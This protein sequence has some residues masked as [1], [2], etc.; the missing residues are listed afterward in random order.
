MTGSGRGAYRCGFCDAAFA[1]QEHLSR[2]TRTHTR[3]KPFRCP[4]DHCAKAFSRQDVLNRHLNAHRHPSR[5]ASTARACLECAALRVRCSRGSP[6]SRCHDHWTDAVASAGHGLSQPCT[7]DFYNSAVLFGGGGGLSAVNWLS[8]Q[9]QHD[10]AWN[11][12]PMPFQDS[13]MDYD[14]IAWPLP[15]DN[16]VPEAWQPVAFPDAAVPPSQGIPTSDLPAAGQTTTPSQS[17]VSPASTKSS[18]RGALYVDGAAGRAPFGGRLLA[19]QR[20]R[21]AYPAATP[22]T[23][24]SAQETR[25]IVS[26]LAYNIMCQEITQSG[27]QLSPDLR[28]MLELA[29]LR[30]WVDLYFE[31]FHPHFPILRKSPE[32]FEA[33]SGWRVLLAAATMGAAH[34]GGTAH[35]VLLDLSDTI[36]IPSGNVSARA[37]PRPDS[38]VGELR[39]LQASALI[40]IGLL[41]AGNHQSRRRGMMLRHHVSEQCR[42]M[43]LLTFKARGGST[44]SDW[45]SAQSEHR[46]GFMIWLLDSII[47]YEFGRAPAFRLYDAEAPLPCTEELWDRPR[48]GSAGSGDLTEALEMLYMEKRLPPNLSEF[49]KVLLTHAVCRRMD[50]AAYQSQA[51]LSG[52]IPDASFQR[53]GSATAIASSWPPSNPLV[54]KW[55]NSSC[56]CLDVLHWNANM[57]CAGAGGFEHP[58]ILHLHLS[59]LF[60]LSPVKHLHV[61]ASE[62]P[63]RTGPRARNP[64]SEEAF[65]NIRKWAIMD[66]YKARLCIIHA[67]AILWHLRRY[68]TGLFIEPFATYLAILVIWSHGISTLSFERHMSGMEAD[69]SA[70]QG[71][72]NTGTTTPMDQDDDEDDDIGFIHLDRPCD[73]EIVQLY[74]RGKKMEANM[75]RIGNICSSGAPQKVLREGLRM[76]SGDKGWTTRDLASVPP[77]QSGS[78]SEFMDRLIN[79]A[80]ATST[81]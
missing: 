23:P 4:H 27:H 61:V 28:L 35:Q 77:S 62:T 42:D 51:A 10:I 25:P 39:E 34:H 74:V 68:N 36:L 12:I 53:R 80:R 46:T 18:Q 73:D 9:F 59:R 79:L 67:G 15:T 17:V 5:A 48:T 22:A 20:S 63:V 71:S 26:E 66:Q 64:R 56:D 37:S 29:S 54:M 57:L 6:C 24:H 41:H 69:E 52:W 49:S 13:S 3:E 50:E 72:S 60:L 58:T 8:P 7:N 1:R 40:M 75:V 47:S 38:R 55:R 44:L 78:T 21:V 65:S 16:A 81:W 76:L 14:N 43:G 19:E 32:S 70:Q 33:S 31:K 2:H 30:S 45:A 11:E